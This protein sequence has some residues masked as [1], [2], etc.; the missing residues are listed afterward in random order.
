[1]PQQYL[2]P[3]P[4]R[5]DKITQSK[6]KL[7]CVVQHLL[8]AP[9][10][11]YD[12]I[13]RRFAYSATHVSHLCKTL[14]NVTQ[15]IRTL[16]TPATRYFNGQMGLTF[17]HFYDGMVQCK[18]RKTYSLFACLTSSQSKYIVSMHHLGIY[19][20]NKRPTNLDDVLDYL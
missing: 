19:L 3:Q 11:I 10:H 2:Q 13:C 20:Y 16:D 9:L 6:F 15:A 5:W 1:M 7:R 8:N 17:L 18:A 14:A 12:R 4:Q